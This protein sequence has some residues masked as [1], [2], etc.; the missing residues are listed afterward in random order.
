[1]TVVGEAANGRAAVSQA[2][3][4]RPDVVVMDI[5][6][7]EL[8]GIDAAREIRAQL[9][10]TQVVM[11]SMQ[12]SAEHMVRALQAGALGCLFKES[13]GREVLDAIG[14]V[15]AGRRYICRQIGDTVIDELL[16]PG[17]AVPART[18]AGL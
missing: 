11:L 5:A 18:P 1:V 10:D 8:N 9:P 17:T 12:T 4:W 13:A 6:V 16:R 14:A 2:L 7:P 15:H 3:T